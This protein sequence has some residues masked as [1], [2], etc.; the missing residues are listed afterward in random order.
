MSQT[1]PVPSVVFETTPCFSELAGLVEHLDAVVAAIADV[2]R[3][4]L[5]DLA[6]LTLGTACRSAAGS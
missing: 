2:D 1:E 3:A 4:V 6:Q 5:R